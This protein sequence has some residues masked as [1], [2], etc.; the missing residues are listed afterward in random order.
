MNEWPVFGKET[1]IKAGEVS[2]EKSTVYSDISCQKVGLKGVKSKGVG[3]GHAGQGDLK[4]RVR[5][6]QVQV[7]KKKKWLE[8]DYLLASDRESQE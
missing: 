5:M 8:G 2:R 6:S 7:E 4:R 3:S 1:S